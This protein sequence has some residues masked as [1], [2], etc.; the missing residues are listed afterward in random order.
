VVAAIAAA[1]EFAAQFAF[2][3]PPIDPDS[4]LLAVVVLAAGIAYIVGGM[5]GRLLHGRIDTVER[6][7]HQIP[8]G[9]LVA[10][11]LGAAGGL[12]L[13]GALVWPVL[14]FGG[15]AVT[16]PLAALVAVVLAATGL[17]VGRARGGDLL[18]FLGMPGRLQPSATA[19]G[20]RAKVL[21]TSALIDGRVLDVCRA[22]FLEGA[23]VVPVFVLTELQGLADA[24]DDRRRTR[25]R[26]GLDVLAALQRSAGVSLEVAETDYPEIGDV[27]AKLLAL[28]RDL[29]AA[30]VSVDGNLG[31]IAEI[32][33]IRVLNLHHLADTLRPPVLPGDVLSVQVTR[34]GK[35][36]EQGVGH[37]EDGTMVVVEGARD[38]QGQEVA[39]EVTS[40]LSTGNGRMVFSRLLDP[41]PTPLRGIR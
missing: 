29:G 28:S 18:R 5:L 19:Q 17:R 9:E 37:L 33:G 22:G 14:L 15:Q 20:G 21:D 41:P 3:W 35:E 11:A 27:D 23:L 40:V 34:P 36:A 31:R 13:A 8:T 10:G 16:L 26:R 7:F 32:Q 30:L 1:F 6:R 2:D 39:V 4:A 24:G 12:V 38:R 25:G